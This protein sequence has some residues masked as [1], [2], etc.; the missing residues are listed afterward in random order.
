MIFEVGKRVWVGP[1]K[2]E[3]TIKRIYHSSSD[4]W[5]DEN[6]PEIGNIE[7]IYDDGI[8]GVSNNW[9]LCDLDDP[10]RFK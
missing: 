10:R 8:I 9:Q 4:T 3:A 1:L 2:M 6:I 5:D 7:L